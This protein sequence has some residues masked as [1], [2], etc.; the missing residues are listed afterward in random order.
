MI[1]RS[2]LARTVAVALTSAIALGAAPPAS[3]G[4]LLADAG[5]CRSDVPE[6]PFL[7]WADL[8]PYV[9]VP[10]GDLER[11][12]RWTLRGGAKQVSGNEPFLVNDEDDR[13]SL[14]LP[15]GAS[16]TTA[17]MCVGV[18]H[19]TL[20]FFARNQGSLLSTLEVEVLYEDAAGHIRALP[21]G[22]LLRGPSWQPT[23]PLPLLVNLMALAPGDRTAVAFR[24]TA[25]GAGDWSIDDVYVDPW[26]HG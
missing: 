19:P 24:F 25:V 5:E 12:A 15:A 16:A 8:A 20:R 9:L 11:G 14:H 13:S 3:A 6:Q 7:P 10:E 4:S 26:R 1:L 18:E 22:G 2:P 17:A 21:I 23:P